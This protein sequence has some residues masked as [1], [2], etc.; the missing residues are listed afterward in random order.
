MKIV[1][2]LVLYTLFATFVGVFSVWPTYEL[3]GEQR[4]ILSLVFSHAGQRI[5]DCRMLSQDELNELPPNMRTVND[6]PRERHPVRV[7]LRSGDEVLYD[8][9]LAPSGIW[10]D[11]KSSI[12]KRL[13]VDS[14]LHELFVGINDSGGK[15]EFDYRQSVVV[16]LPPGR[17]LVVQFDEKTQQISIR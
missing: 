16:D 1:S 7:L 17:N 14:G 4:A 2:E 10:A 8:A 11:G 5:G 13:E 15:T 9:T 6:C 12:Y 3:V